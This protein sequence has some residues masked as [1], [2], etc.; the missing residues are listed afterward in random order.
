MSS[1]DKRR[2]TQRV[3]SHSFSVLFCESPAYVIFRRTQRSSLWEDIARQ[4]APTHTETYTHLLLVLL[5]YFSRVCDSHP[6]GNKQHFALRR[7]D[8]E[9]KEACVPRVSSSL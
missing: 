7:E 4:H 2:N 8:S 1:R 5:F 3:L 6:R 9:E